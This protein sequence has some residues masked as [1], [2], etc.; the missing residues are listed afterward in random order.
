LHKTENTEPSIRGWL[1]ILKFGPCAAPP[2]MQRWLPPAKEGC[3]PTGPTQGLRA[4]VRPTDARCTLPPFCFGHIDRM[5]HRTAQ[6][7]R[8]VSEREDRRELKRVSTT[9]VGYNRRPP[10]RPRTCRPAPPRS[11]TCV[12]VSGR[13]RLST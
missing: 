5:R 10:R 1:T 8:D 7:G 4:W 6:S 9:S 12:G 13:S 2:A 11:Q 3:R